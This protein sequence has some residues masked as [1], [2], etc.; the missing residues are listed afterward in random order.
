MKATTVKSEIL[1][2]LKELKEKGVNVILEESF[3]DRGQGYLSGTF[4]VNSDSI[5]NHAVFHHG[6]QLNVKTY[7]KPSELYIHIYQN[8]NE[9]EIKNQIS[10]I[11]RHIKQI[12]EECKSSAIVDFINSELK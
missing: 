11:K 7:K 12:E 5:V 9:E 4:T 10:S 2:D 8:S 6:S 3:I 1:K